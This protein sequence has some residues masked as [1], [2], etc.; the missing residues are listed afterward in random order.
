MMRDRNLARVWFQCLES[1]CLIGSKIILIYQFFFRGLYKS[2]CGRVGALYN[3]YRNFERAT[4]GL[5]LG[6]GR[7]PKNPFGA[8]EVLGIDLFDNPE[9]YVS[10]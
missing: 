8:T 7:S 9:P 5:D 6:C 1:N 3:R 10:R 2:R 4:R